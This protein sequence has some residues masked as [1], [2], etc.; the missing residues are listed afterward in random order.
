MLP[1]RVNNNRQRKKG[2]NEIKKK[3]WRENRKK[4]K[5]DLFPWRGETGNTIC[6]YD[7]SKP[8][9]G[10]IAA[11]VVPIEAIRWANANLTL[12]TPLSRTRSDNSWIFEHRT[13]SRSLTCR[14]FDDLIPI[15]HLTRHFET[16]A[17]KRIP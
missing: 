4:R 17:A 3:G 12:H 14:F 11:D 13:D 10:G 7:R 8:S 9:S 6:T 2:R 1:N 5:L 15:D 16:P